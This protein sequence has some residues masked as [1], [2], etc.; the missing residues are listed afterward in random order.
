MQSLYTGMLL[1][2]VIVQ[3]VTVP[4]DCT[5]TC[6]SMISELILSMLDV[7][8]STDERKKSKTTTIDFGKTTIY[9]GR[10]TNDCDRTTVDFARTHDRF[11]EFCRIWRSIRACNYCE[12]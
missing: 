3:G 8:Y 1:Y 5:S 6:S 12:W 7:C 9:F 2:P 4:C 11:S 10:T